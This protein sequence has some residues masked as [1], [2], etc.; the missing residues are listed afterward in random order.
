ME[1]EG[2][3]FIDALKYLAERNGIQLPKTRE[4]KTALS[5]EA[6][7]VLSAYDWLSKYYYHLLRYS[8]EGKNAL[9]YIINRGINEKTIER[10]QL[11]FSPINSDVTVQFLQKKGFHQQVLLKAGLLSKRD[12]KLVDP[13]RGRIIFPIRNHLGR[14]VA[15]G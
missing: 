13:F 2:F 7:V 10:F 4:V 12:R 5:E 11:G 8:E 1:I 6:N 15:F 14:T 9:D 3:S